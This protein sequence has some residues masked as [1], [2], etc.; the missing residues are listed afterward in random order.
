MYSLNVTIV[1]PS[2]VVTILS[3]CQWSYQLKI[4]MKR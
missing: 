1:D 4:V 3:K 2:V